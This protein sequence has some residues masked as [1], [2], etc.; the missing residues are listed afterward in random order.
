MNIKV[1]WERMKEFLDRDY[2]SGKE[3]FDDGYYVYVFDGAILRNCIIKGNEKEEYNNN[4]C[5]KEFTAEKYGNDLKA[6]LVSPTL[7]DV[8]GLYPKKKMFKNIALPGE[9]NI[10]DV[11]VLQEKRI[12]GG[13]YWIKG[14]DVNKVHDN[15]YV[16]FAVVDK[17]NVLGLFGEYGLVVGTDILE[18]TKFVITD[19]V[20]KGSS[21]DCYHSKLYEGIKGTNKVI[22][23]LFIRII[24]DSFGS[25]N[26]ELLWRLYYYE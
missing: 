3:T 9:F 10:F 20:K 26:L 12:C 17:N 5:N 6:K 22:P 1:S 13:E 4:Y 11:E 18:V 25:E 19:Y 8:L 2:P 21:N 14:D 15:D 24:Y 16:E 23:G 7:D